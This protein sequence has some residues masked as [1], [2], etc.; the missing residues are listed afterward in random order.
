MG[1]DAIRFLQSP[2]GVE[3]LTRLAA[4][5]LT[6]DNALEVLTRLRVRHPASIS[7]ALLE[8]ARQRQAAVRKFTDP[9]QL[10]FDRESLE[11]CS[12]E[13][14]ARHR[15]RRFAEVGA[16]W[17]ADLGC[18]AGGDAMALSEAA[19]V[20]GLDRS[21]VRLLMAE[22]NVSTVN[23][24]F[25][26]VEG[27]IETLPFEVDGRA[28]FLDPAR[29]EGRRRRFAPNQFS[30]PLDVAIEVARRARMGAI[31][32][33]P[34]ID[35]DAL[36]DDAEAEFVSHLGELKECVL[37][38]GSARSDARRR[39][40]LVGVGSL[41]PDS[42]GDI[43]V[44]DGPRAFLIEPDP[45]VIRAGIVR[46][47]ARRL[48]AV[49]LDRTIAYLTTELRP[50]DR[51]GKVYEVESSLPFN[52][53]RLRSHLRELDVGSVTVKKRGSA[54]DPEDLRRRLK[55]EGSDHRVVVITR[56]QGAQ[57]AIICSS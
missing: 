55:L 45:A 41:A 51:F 5:E 10:I 11:Q 18:G 34:G 13:P 43:D 15:S 27:A 33:A 26:A 3:E 49:M 21:R 9:G 1:P 53:K 47:L 44:A 25:H 17:V 19:V 35:H 29:R 57:T 50:D 56:V 14:V 52:L 12:S 39:A 20:V 30:P 7:A 40:S 6:D 36:P 23:G 24:V 42:G 8:V 37:W 31:K 32:V 16:D 46:T 2:A 54:I 28:V 38:F 48:G 22:H 4:I